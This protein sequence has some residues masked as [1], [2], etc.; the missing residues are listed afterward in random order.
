MQ[1][2][3]KYIDKANEIKVATKAL[4]EGGQLTFVKGNP[5]D[6]GKAKKKKVDTKK[7]EI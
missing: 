1:E 2:V 5:V 6:P 4:K 3:T 7:V